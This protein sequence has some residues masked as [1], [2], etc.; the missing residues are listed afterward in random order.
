MTASAA[1]DRGREAFRRRA[2]REA[3]TQLSSAD[4]ESPLGAEDLEL[5]ATAAYL[6]GR[7]ADSAAAWERAHH[8]Y[9]GRGE[10]AHAVRCAFWLALGLVTRGEVA[11][12][13]GWFARAQRLI[14]EGQLDC[15]EQGYLLMAVG[16][17]SV[18]AGDYAEGYATFER[19]V[20]IGERFADPDLVALAR[21]GLGRALIRL[22]QT[23]AGVALLD[24]VMVAVTSGEVSPVPTGLVYCSVIEACNEIFDVR[25]AHE[26]TAALVDW[27]AS[28][29]DLVPYR[30]Q[31]LV[32]RSQVMQLRGAWP[33]AMDELRR[34]CE[35]FSSPPGQPALGM[36]L[37][38]QAELHRLRGDFALAEE[39]YRQASQ[40]GHPPQPGLAQLR[41][42]QGRVDAAAAAIRSAANEAQDRLARARVLAAY[43][44]IVLASGDLDASR[45]AADELS[46]IAADIGAPLLQAVATHA[47][48]A[49]LLA[50]GDAQAALDVLR[51]AGQAWAELEAPYDAARTRVLVGLARRQLGDEDT[52]R[53]ELDAAR[54][55]FRR[56]GA[57]PDL[58]RVDALTHRRPATGG[59]SAREAEVLRLV[60]A[61][62]TNQ[63]IAAELFLSEKTVARHVSN[64]FIKLG[65]SSRAAATAYAY[66]HG[67]I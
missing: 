34:A 32:H 50:E 53:L 8:E 47:R 10:T 20:K 44:E 27:V 49:V 18:A 26:W 45:A 22:G 25:R 12:G 24:E 5:L 51:Q 65:V 2:W 7:D 64:I 3:W 43:V 61:G 63:A 11:R 13:S 19:A 37:Y 59:L 62:K 66:E 35:R 6:L 17:R 58:A 48:G 4:Q 54:H 29:P 21:H 31:C 52:A 15:V 30:G 67:L 46:Q 1:L 28:Q 36:A 23:A 33:D 42:A 14:D 56:L 60:A 9:Q 38:Q 55:V 41:L 40:W 39:A 57:A 16:L